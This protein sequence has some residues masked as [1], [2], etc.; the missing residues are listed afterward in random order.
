MRTEVVE[1]EVVVVLEGDAADAIPVV[2]DKAEVTT[3][4][5]H[6]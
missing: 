2:V 1:A 3:I 5:I 6:I 4:I